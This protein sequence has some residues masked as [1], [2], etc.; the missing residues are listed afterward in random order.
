MGKLREKRLSEQGKWKTFSKWESVTMCD[1]GTKKLFFLTRHFRSSLT[2][3][4]VSRG[5]VLR[6]APQGELLVIWA[7]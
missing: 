2:H 6:R 5:L 1:K 4:G 7:S 3:C